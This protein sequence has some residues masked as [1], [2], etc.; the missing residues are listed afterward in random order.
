MHHVRRL[1]EEKVVDGVHPIPSPLDAD[2]AGEGTEFV[3]GHRLKGG[4]GGVLEDLPIGIRFHLLGT[5]YW[6]MS[7]NARDFLK[8]FLKSRDPEMQGKSSA[9]NAFRLQEG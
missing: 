8:N 2:A 4:G 7:G 3:T 5:I 1:G 9:I 6:E